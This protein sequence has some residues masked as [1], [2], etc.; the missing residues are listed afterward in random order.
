MCTQAKSAETAAVPLKKRK[1][2]KGGQQGGGKQLQQQTEQGSPQRQPFDQI[3]PDPGSAVQQFA[4][5][6]LPLGD[7]FR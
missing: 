1:K 7:R 6:A 2:G 4:S 3:S 5:P